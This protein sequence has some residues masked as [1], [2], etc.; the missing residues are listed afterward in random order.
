PRCLAN[1]QLPGHVFTARPGQILA[2]HLE[3]R[4]DSRDP[5]STLEV[6]QDGHVVRTVPFAEFKRTGALATLTFRES[7]WFLVRARADVSGTFRFASTGP[8]Y[9]EIGP[10]TRRISRASASFFLEWLRER[11]NGIKL[12]D[13]AQQAEVLTYHR[14]AEK[15]WQEKL[16]QA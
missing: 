12:E 15:F 8:F 9:V 14:Q 4:L 11:M 7:G 3:A 6:V 1:G 16:A 13:R 5:I 2:L 10:N